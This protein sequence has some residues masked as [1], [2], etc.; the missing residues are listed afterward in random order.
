MNG[1]RAIKRAPNRRRAGA[2]NRRA[3]QVCDGILSLYVAPKARYVNV[4]DP[5][6]PA[7]AAGSAEGGA[8]GGAGTTVR[9]VHFSGASTI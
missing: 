2:L 8:A 7:P 9:R 1:S 4:R 3:P 6:A 5:A